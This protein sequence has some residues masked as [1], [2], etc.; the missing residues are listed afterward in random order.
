MNAASEALRFIHL[1]DIHF[2]GSS[3][4]P[5]DLDRDIRNE[6]VKDAQSLLNR[7]LVTGIL[8]CGDI[9]WSGREAEYQVAANWLV[10]LCEELQCAKEFVWTVPGNHDVDRKTIESSRTAQ[11]LRKMIRQMENPGPSLDQHLQDDEAKDI[12]IK[13]LSSYNEFAKRYQCHVT[14]AQP[15]WD[16]DMILNDGSTLRLRGLTSVFVSDRND[17]NKSNKL[18]IASSHIVLQRKPQVAWM[19]LCHHP[20]DWLVNHDEVE[21]RLRVRAHVQLFGHKH[22]QRLDINERAGFK[23]LRLGSGAVHPERDETGWEPRYNLLSVEVVGRGA[24][25]KLA[26][27]VDCR[28]WDAQALRFK[29]DGDP[30]RFFLPLETWQ[31]TPSA[32]ESHPDMT[33]SMV[34]TQIP[35]QQTAPGALVNTDLPMDPYRRLVYRFFS[36]PHLDQTRIVTVLGLVQP[37]DD[38]LDEAERVGLCFERARMANRL[39]ELWDAVAKRHPDSG[40][41]PNPFLRA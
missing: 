19:T 27:S 31:P 13:S 12:F 30:Q 37:G 29:A 22:K 18:V 10:Q 1:A 15:Y 33:S 14:A 36:L 39:A 34:P 11:S 32:P 4:I 6:L 35:P 20:P 40:T 8:V 7:D 24:A 21:D 28:R 25:R 2:R 41:E 3:G 17:D 16:R 9:A 26:V 5:T 38:M 23:S